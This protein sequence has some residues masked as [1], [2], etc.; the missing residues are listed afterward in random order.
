M[1]FGNTYHE[2]LLE[3][4]LVT[5]FFLLVIFGISGSFDLTILSTSGSVF[6]IEE[7]FSRFKLIFLSSFI[8]FFFA[9][10]FRLNFTDSKTRVTPEKIIKKVFQKVGKPKNGTRKIKIPRKKVDLLTIIV[11]LYPENSLI[12]NITEIILFEPP[13]N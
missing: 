1:P 9:I 4:F 12:S 6:A 13:S 11:P 7:M 3:E 10:L 5:N 2:V 8:I